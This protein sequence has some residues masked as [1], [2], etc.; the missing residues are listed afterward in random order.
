MRALLALLALVVAAPAWA[1]AEPVATVTV[2][3]DGDSWTAEY[4]LHEQAPVW[5]FAKSILPRESKLPWRLTTVRVLTPGVTL[6]RIGNYDALVVDDKPLPK[7]VRLS[8]TPFLEDIEG[9]YD[10]A[11]AL[12]DGSVA[13]YANQFQLVPIASVEAA[14][15]APADD[16]KLPQIDR[17]TRM[18]FNDRSGPV[19]VH[20]RRQDSATMERGQTYV[21]FGRAEPVVGSAMTT[22]IDPGLP[23]WIAEYIETELPTV[24]GRYQDELGPS[25]VGQPTLLVSWAGPTPSKI[26]MGGSVLPGMVVMTLEGEG[27]LQPDERIAQRARWFVAHEAAHFW[28]GQ[29]VSY[30][31]RSESW[32]T[33]GGA[34][35]LAFR[36][37]AAADPAFDVKARLAEAKSEC[38]PF[39]ARGGIASAYQRDA[40][41]RAYYAC[42][43]VLALAAEKA[44][45]RNFADFV[46]TLID[47]YGAD[48]KV[49]RGEWMTLLD[50]RSPGLSAAAAKLLDKAHSDPE[51]ALEEFIQAA[52]IAD[53][54]EPSEASPKVA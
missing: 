28:L 19:L 41:F 49:T 14:R 30:S 26:S 1:S 27:I 31:E 3:R 25:P 9:G 40:D 44:S 8:F 38:L 11:L 47:R 16:S 12:T 33:E 48:G 39:L 46:R 52:G 18:T 23:E 5:V 17:P 13:L 20:G 32:I 2:E 54:F 15:A 53:Q 6:E 51:R 37:T 24:L 7:R 50:E 43:V 34:E 22:I 10:P 42:G 45:G 36:A 35:L 21:L 4:E 29:A